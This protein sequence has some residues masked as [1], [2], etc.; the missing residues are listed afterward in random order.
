MRGTWGTRQTARNRNAFEV[1]APSSLWKCGEDGACALYAVIAITY[2]RLYLS[3]CIEPTRRTSCPRAHTIE[4]RNFTTW[5]PTPTPSPLNPTAKQI[6]LPLTNSAGRLT[7]TRKTLI[8]IPNNSPRKRKSPLKNRPE[9]GAFGL[10]APDY[11]AITSVSV[12]SRL[13]A[14]STFSAFCSGSICLSSPQST[15]PGASSMKT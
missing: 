11:A 9:S 5:Q 6:I 15:V 8:S 7:N 4:P 2:R 1:Q 12:F 14:F 3:F 10:Y 13:A